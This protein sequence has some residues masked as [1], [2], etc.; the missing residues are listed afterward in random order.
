MP[1]EESAHR[2]LKVRVTDLS[3]ERVG[4]DSSKTALRGRKMI[5]FSRSDAKL[6][7]PGGAS[8]S[9]EGS[10]YFF[11]TRMAARI[12]EEQISI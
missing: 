5:I 11:Q 10:G 12:N 3:R 4:L 8:D 7:R 6:E 9:H 1:S 2:K